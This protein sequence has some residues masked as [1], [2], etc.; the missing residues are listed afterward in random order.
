MRE[1]WAIVIPSTREGSDLLSSDHTRWVSPL[2]LFLEGRSARA[3]LALFLG[4][5]MI[6]VATAKFEIKM[7]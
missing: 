5:E 6:A 1:D 3:E 7:L 4:F 2:I